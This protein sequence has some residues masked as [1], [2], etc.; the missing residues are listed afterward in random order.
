M[1]TPRRGTHAGER[2]HLIRIQ[3]KVPQ[4]DPEYGGSIGT[5]VWEDIATVWAKR[6]N[7]LRPAAETVAAGAVVAKETVRWDIL[8]RAIDPAWRIVHAGKPY[9]IQAGGISNDNRE[10]AIITT[11]GASD[12]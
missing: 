7:L 8:A 10:T 4:D 11:T 12:G 6:T 3:R 1:V 5:A 9:D 2:R